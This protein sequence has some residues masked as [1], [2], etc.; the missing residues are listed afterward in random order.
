M[1]LVA[2]VIGIAMVK[3]GFFNIFGL[4]GGILGILGARAIMS[5]NSAP[6]AMPP[7]AAPM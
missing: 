3:F 7:A 5:G 1:A 2:E 4:V 6:Q